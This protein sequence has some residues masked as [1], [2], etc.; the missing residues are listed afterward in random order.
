MYHAKPMQ[1]AL[2]ALSRKPIP[3]THAQYVTRLYRKSLRAVFSWA[4]SRD[5]FNEEAE[6]IRFGAFFLTLFCFG[7]SCFLLSVL[8][9]FFNTLPPSFHTMLSPCMHASHLFTACYDAIETCSGAECT[10]R[11]IVCRRRR[12]SKNARKSSSPSSTRTRTS[13]P[14]CLAALSLCETPPFLSVS[15]PSS[16]CVSFFL[17][18]RHRLPR[19][20]P[21]GRQPARGPYRL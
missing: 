21:Q 18:F 16:L 19:W 3:L 17:F 8:N 11:W 12:P 2:K 5:V 7:L 9:P 15:S 6:K 20:H 4:V 1:E 13:P 10:F 14:T